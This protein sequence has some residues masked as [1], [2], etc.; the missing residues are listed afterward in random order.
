[1]LQIYCATIIRS[2]VLSVLWIA[3]CTRTIIF[4]YPV[5]PFW[6]ICVRTINLLITYLITWSVKDNIANAA[7]DYIKTPWLW[8]GLLQ[9]LGMPMDFAF[10]GTQYLLMETILYV[11]AIIAISWDS[12]QFKALEL[13]FCFLYSKF[14]GLIIYI[15][16]CFL[17]VKW[18]FLSNGKEKFLM[19]HGPL[20]FC[21]SQHLAFQL[22]IL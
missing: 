19:W 21:Y 13:K 18:N 11:M 16:Q 15:H 8:N 7:I 5:K 9:Y 14:S 10:R 22:Y 20:F 3:V 6:E 1:M 17:H 12:S 4:L 2:D